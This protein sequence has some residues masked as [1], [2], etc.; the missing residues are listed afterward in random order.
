MTN[1]SMLMQV[2]DVGNN[3]DMYL[4]PFKRAEIQTLEGIEI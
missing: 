1:Y 3:S 4:L 2:R